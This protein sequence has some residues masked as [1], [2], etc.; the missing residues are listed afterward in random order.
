MWWDSLVALVGRARRR[1]AQPQR[2]FA[3][4]DGAFPGDQPPFVWHVREADR[5]RDQ[6]DPA[7]AA[8]AYSAALALAPDRTDIRVQLGN[9]LKDSGQHAQ[10]E[11]VYRH[12][13]RDRPDVADTHL[14]LG[15]VLKMR[16][17]HSAA[18]REYRRASELDPNSAP[19]VIELASERWTA[20]L[21]MGLSG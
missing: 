9:M 16:G 17:R 13:L 21:I 19:A 15:H 8:R 2:P 10:A 20:I 12:A 7:A 18:L 6:G 5:L 14:Q 11:A 3:P 1:R 4:S